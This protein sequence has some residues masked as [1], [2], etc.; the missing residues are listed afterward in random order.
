VRVKRGADV[1]DEERE[2]ALRWLLKEQRLLAGLTQKQL[3][4]RMGR[5][6][7]FVS[8]SENGQHR[9]SVVEFLRFCDALELDPR[10]AIRRVAAGKVRPK[11][12]PPSR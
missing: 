10:S 6:Q 11:T 5:V 9:V 2:L 3:A 8:D 7:S 4:E 12:K 1:D